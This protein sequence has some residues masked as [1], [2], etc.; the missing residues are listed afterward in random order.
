[1]RVGEPFTLARETRPDGGRETL[2]ETTTRLM[3]RIAELLPERHR[4]FYAPLL[5][6]APSGPGPGPNEE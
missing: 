2:Q 5:A 3:L 4:G 6:A 1:M